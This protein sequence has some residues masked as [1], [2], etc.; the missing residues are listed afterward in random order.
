MPKYIWKMLMH[1]DDKNSQL[2]LERN[3]LNL[4]KG[5]CQKPYSWLH[6]EQEKGNEGYNYHSYVI[7]IGNLNVIRQ[8]KE[9]KYILIRKEDIEMHLFTDNI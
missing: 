8:E 7:Y 6:L 1:T 3:Y 5:I 4:I 2:K 9:I